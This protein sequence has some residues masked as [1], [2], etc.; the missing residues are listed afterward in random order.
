M[1][2][3]VRVR[4]DLLPLAEPALASRAVDEV[5]TRDCPAGARQ[6]DGHSMHAAIFQV[7]V[8]G[9]PAQITFASYCRFR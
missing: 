4:N 8:S 7:A 3:G 6:V 1:I 2:A 5:G 9:P